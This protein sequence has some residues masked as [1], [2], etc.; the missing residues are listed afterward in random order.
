[1]RLGLGALLLTHPGAWHALRDDPDL[2]PAAVEEILRVPGKG[3]GG[4]PRYA[5]TDLEV[6]GVTIR[7]GDVVTLSWREPGRS[8]SG[9]TVG[10]GSDALTSRVWSCDLPGGGRS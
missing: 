8:V 4:I 10:S 1:M 9:L 5:R 2:I 3:R 6:G 7:T